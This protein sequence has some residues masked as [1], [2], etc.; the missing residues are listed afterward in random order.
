VI[1]LAQTILLKEVD[2]KFNI[3]NLRIVS[4]SGKEQPVGRGSRRPYGPAVIVLSLLMGFFG[5]IIGMVVVASTPETFQKKLGI[6]QFKNLVGDVVN[7]Q[8]V[9]VEEDSATIQVVKDVS[10][11]V[12]SVIFTKNVSVNDPFGF[13]GQSGK[14]IEQQGGGTGFIITSDGLIV[15]NKHVVSDSSAKY[16]VVMTDGKTY[17]ASVVAQDPT[18]DLAVIKIDAKGL[19][20]VKLGSSDGMKV[21]Q[22]VIAIGNALGEYQ[23]TVTTGVLSATGRSVVAS[24][25]NSQNTE[26]LDGLLQT[27]AAINLGNSGGPLVNIAGQV[28]GINTV[29]ASKGSAEGIGFAIPIDVAKSAIESVKKTGKIVRPLL[30]VNTIEITKDIA[31]INNLPVSDGYLIASDTASGTQAIVSGSPADKAGLR[32][33]DIITEINGK[34]IG[35]NLSLVSALRDF[36]PGDEVSIKFIRDGKDKTVKVKLTERNE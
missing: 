21:G 36:T 15:T 4:K 18:L 28:I 27:D 13:Y 30:G 3:K 8:K 6:S 11:A 19:P 33:G 2:V 34:A 9:T 14:T 29:T 31:K 1:T 25:S 22:R 5:G 17:D 26:S 10:P 12:V 7:T 24:D 20:V 23:N 35:K 16:T 32:E